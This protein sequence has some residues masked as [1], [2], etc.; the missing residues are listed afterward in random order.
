MTQQITKV[1][2]GEK[3]KLFDTHWDPKI[4]A[5]YNGN[6][7]MVVKFQGA[8]PFHKH[9]D[10]DDFF[11]ILDDEVV[12]D[13]EDDD[14]VTLGVGEICVIPA[15]VIHRPHAEEEAKVLLMEP[16]GLPNTGDADTAAEKPWI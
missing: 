1:N 3:L 16:A 5:Q 6:D 4:V 14:S 7:L 8:F 13:Q 9:D 12:M 10:S 11:L 15:G 2:L